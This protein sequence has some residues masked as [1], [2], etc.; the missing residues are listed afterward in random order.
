MYYLDYA[1]KPH[2]GNQLSFMLHELVFLGCHSQ[3]ASYPYTFA[4]HS[5]I[6]NILQQ[7]VVVTVRMHSDAIFSSIGASRMKTFIKNQY[8]GVSFVCSH[9][10]K[11]APDSTNSGST[12]P[13]KDNFDVSVSHRP[14]TSSSSEP[15]LA[16]GL[17]I[18]LASVG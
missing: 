7:Y 10:I 9:F 2:S 8:I 3:F 15:S 16:L 1:E 4:S 13:D 17:Q 6:C 5:H 12:I 11:S 14:Q 18:S